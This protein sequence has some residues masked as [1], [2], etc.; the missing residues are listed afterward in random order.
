MPTIGSACHELRI[1]DG[2]VSWRVMYHV[3]GDAIV[4]LD[5]LKKKTEATPLSE[6]N[7]CKRRLADFKRLAA[8]KEKDRAKR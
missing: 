1:V 4:I 6:I 5:V 8:T 3:A 2:K 7:G